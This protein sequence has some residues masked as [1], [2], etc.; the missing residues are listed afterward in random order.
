MEVRVKLETYG[1]YQCCKE[2]GARI[3]SDTNIC[4]TSYPARY[5]YQC[6]ECGYRGISVLSPRIEYKVIE[7]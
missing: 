5:Y 1:I 4:L 3:E 6:K 2:C 7:G